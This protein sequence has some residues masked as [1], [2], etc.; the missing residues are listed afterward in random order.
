M[1]SKFHIWFG[2][3]LIILS[4]GG[5]KD[6]ARWIS[7]KYCLTSCLNFFCW[8]G[9][10]LIRNYRYFARSF[11]FS[12]F[13]KSVTSHKFFLSSGR[14]FLQSSGADVQINEHIV[15]CTPRSYWQLGVRCKY[16]SMRKT[17]MHFVCTYAT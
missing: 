15:Y 4:L 1:N 8:S 3:F 13:K 17:K 11:I 2:L 7:I 6:N 9:D 12:S 14:N 5:R 10:G 16:E